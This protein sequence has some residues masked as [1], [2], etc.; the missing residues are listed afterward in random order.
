MRSQ[1]LSIFAICIFFTQASFAG[2]IITHYEG[3]KSDILEKKAKDI[4]P[5]KEG[6]ADATKIA[7]KLY[8]ELKPR[9]PLAFL[10]APQIGISKQIFIYSWNRGA[11]NMIIVINPTITNKKVGTSEMWEVNPS[12]ITKDGEV[13]AVLVRRP[14]VIEV[15]YMDINGNPQHKNLSGRAARAFMQGYD[16]LQGVNHYKDKKLRIRKFPSYAE[17]EA[18]V[19]S[20]ENKKEPKYY[21]PKNDMSW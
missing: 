14:D 19:K 18:Y 1:F 13:E 12:S 9:L 10:S 8:K 20:L 6:L 21:P 17:Y 11:E 4:E 3:F 7:D 15:M 5:T 16:Y 2:S